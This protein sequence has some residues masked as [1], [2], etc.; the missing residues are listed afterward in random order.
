MIRLLLVVHLNLVFTVGNKAKACEAVESALV[1]NP[2]DE[3]QIRNK[4]FFISEE[5]VTEDFFTPRKVGRHLRNC[6]SV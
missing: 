5:G 1:L 4:Q 3:V 6:L 2:E